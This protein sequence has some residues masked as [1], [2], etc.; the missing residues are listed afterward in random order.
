MKSLR[1]R[2]SIGEL[3]ATAVALVAASVSPLAFDAAAG[4]AMSLHELGKFAV[5]PALL[6]WVALIIMAIVLGWRRLAAAGPIAIVAGIGGTAAMEV[7]RATGFRVF[8]AMPGSMPQLIGVLLADQFMQGPNLA[9]NLLGW[10]DHIWNG[11]GF[12]F[13]YISLIGRGRWWLGVVYATIIATI[14]MLGP[15]MNIIGAGPF[16]QDFAPIMFPL[17]V[18]LAHVA[19][20]TIFGLIVQH[21]RQAP[22]HLLQDAFGISLTD[23]SK[24]VALNRNGRKGY[25]N[26]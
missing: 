11:I 19:Y 3:I 2:I 21:S 25:N 1:L 22:G 16:G 15:V 18:Y 8:D 24:G 6:I 7:V 10:G 4:S 5:L 14:F 12:A 17:T 13:I 20:G 26:G 23:I 9:S